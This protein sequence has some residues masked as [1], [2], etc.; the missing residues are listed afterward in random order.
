MD[1]PSALRE[2]VSDSGS[3]GTH[4][5]AVEVIRGDNARQLDD[6]ARRW[7]EYSEPLARRLQPAGEDPWRVPTQ[8]M[9]D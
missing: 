6:I 8:V 5:G 3:R 2:M 1:N 7:R 9:I 4:D